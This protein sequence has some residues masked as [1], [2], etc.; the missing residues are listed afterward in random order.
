MSR[1]AETSHPP[2]LVSLT[3]HASIPFEV[4]PF[5]PTAIPLAPVDWS[6]IEPHP[7]LGAVE[8]LCAA[9]GAD[10]GD[11]LADAPHGCPETR[12]PFFRGASPHPRAR[13]PPGRSPRRR[14]HAGHGE[15][16]RHRA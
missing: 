11:H 6:A 1:R 16:A 7:E 4:T 10:F 3:G 8:R 13:E 14:S 9:C 2:T 15:V 12:C 5:A